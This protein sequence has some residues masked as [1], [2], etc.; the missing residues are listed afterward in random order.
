MNFL[1]GITIADL[2]RDNAARQDHGAT[3]QDVSDD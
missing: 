3:E 1:R 2:I